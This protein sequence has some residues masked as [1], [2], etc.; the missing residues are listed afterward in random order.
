ME[1][2]NSPGN[3]ETNRDTIQKGRMGNMRYKR[4]GNTDMN[5]SVLTIGTW[6]AGCAEWGEVDRSECIR[7]IHA[8]MDNGVNM[9]DTAPCYNAGESERVVGEALKGRRDKIFLV[10]KTGVYS[11]PDGAAKDGRRESVLRLCDT[12]LRNLQTDYIDLM[13]IHWP[14]TQ[15]NAPI[16]ETMTALEDLKK[17]GKIRHIGVSNFSQA[18]IE[19]ARQFGEVCALEPPYSMVNR[20][21]EQEMLWT[22]Q[23]G[24]ANMTYGSLGA[25]ILTGAFRQ[26]PNFSADDMRVG[27]YDYFREP[28]FSKCL[29]IVEAMDEIAGDRGVPVAQVAINWSTQKDY[30]TT[31]LCGVRSPR[32]AEENCAGMDWTLTQD[33]IDFLDRRIAESGIE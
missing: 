27:F 15:Y 30:V 10:T 11:T 1:G 26:L 4:F 2:I 33:E 19:A 21:A 7:A 31:A 25:G 24:M 3:R 32:E 28:K 18:E 6:V 17:M 16:E 13:L 29:S 5:V 12:S 9:I 23:N 8:M 20:G 14:D 22:H